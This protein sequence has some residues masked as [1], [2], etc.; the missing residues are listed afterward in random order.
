MT[1]DEL[2][3]Y[4][5]RVRPF[6]DAELRDTAE[7]LALQMAR[8]IGIYTKLLRPDTTLTQIL[9]WLRASDR[10]ATSRDD[11]DSVMLLEQALAFEIPD[12]LAFGP[13]ST[14]FLDLVELRAQNLSAA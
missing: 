3:P 1:E 2:G 10:T 4:A 7:E 11:V 14:T 6:F 5:A 13:D 8:H 9:A 12:A